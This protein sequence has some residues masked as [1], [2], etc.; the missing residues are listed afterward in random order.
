[1]KTFPLPEPCGLRPIRPLG[2]LETGGWRIKTYGIAHGRALPRPE[3]V[4]A[5]HALAA[6]AFPVP[7]EGPGRYGVGYLGIHDGRGA[8]WVFADW[9]EGENELRHRVFIAPTGQ[10]TALEE[11]THTSLT[12]CVWDLRVMC[13]ERGAWLAHCLRN[14]AGRPELD[15]YLADTLSEDA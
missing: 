11:H 4:A 2:L 6:T 12:A 1:M 7:A 15:A 13:F 5:A 3:L 8:A 10:P 14:P 9:W